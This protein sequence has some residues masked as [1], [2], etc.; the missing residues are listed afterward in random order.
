M[1]KKICVIVHPHYWDFEKYPFRG[2]D[3]YNYE[4]IKGLKKRGLNIKILDSGFIKS[5]WEGALKELIF[6]FRL[7]WE[8]ADVF[9]ACHP[10]GAKWAILLRKK[11]LV[12][13]IH[14]LLPL[15]YRRGE[16]DSVLKYFFKRLSIK[17]TLK[18]SDKII[19]NSVFYKEWLK[20]EFKLPDNKIDINYYGIDH[21]KF[22]PGPILDNNPKRILF[23]GELIRAKADNLIRAFAILVR[24]FPNV[25]L[26]MAGKGRE[27][28]WLKNLAKELGIGDKIEFAG[29][30]PEED[31]PNL[32]RSADIFAFPS[33]HG[34]G[35]P[36]MEAMACGIPV[37]VSDRFNTVDYVADAGIR[38]NPD[39]PEEIYSA[40]KKLLANPALWNEYRQKG[41][42]YVKNFTWE[43]MVDD[44]L[45]IYNEFDG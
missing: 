3:R 16:Y 28:N 41:L 9:H 11:P 34:T 19:V 6:P 29:K 18:A 45:R 27:E 8:K 39:S 40:L 32:Y 13:F 14:D 25:K 33:R 1:H 24:S 17:L 37:I 15:V 31:L 35:F 7:F 30:I 36:P 22:F 23:L 20:R 38:V 26:I 2:I 21:E 43:R 42:E 4:L 5:N 12:T 10:M 44:T